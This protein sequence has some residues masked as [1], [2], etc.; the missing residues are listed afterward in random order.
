[1]PL[2]FAQQRLW[3]L[4]QLEERPGLYNMP[5][6]LRL[7]ANLGAAQVKLLFNV[8]AEFAAAVGHRDVARKAVSVVFSSLADVVCVSGPMTGEAADASAVARV[9]QALG[10][11]PVFANTGVN[12]DNVGEVLAVADGAIVGTHFKVDGN[13]WN[14]VDAA[15]VWRFMDVV[16]RLR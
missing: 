9:K 16:N 1:M 11:T 10:A 15:R 13:T 14:A 4:N 3:F 12:I 5:A 7:R 8:N 6:A 2:S